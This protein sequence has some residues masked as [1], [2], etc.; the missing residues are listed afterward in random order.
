MN[1]NLLG[2]AN[3]AHFLIDDS[4]KPHIDKVVRGETLGQV[5]ESAGYNTQD[6]FENFRT[7]V[8]NAENQSKITR[9][10]LDSF[11]ESF[12]TTLGSYTYLEE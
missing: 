5:L 4:G 3:E 2:S 12:Q 6:L 1:H 10:E 8:R 9:K 7:M 11:C